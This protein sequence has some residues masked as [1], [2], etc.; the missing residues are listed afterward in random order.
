MILGFYYKFIIIIIII[1][2]FLYFSP[3][4]ILEIMHRSILKNTYMRIKMEK[5]IK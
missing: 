1:L 2:L 3:S 4:I 5:G